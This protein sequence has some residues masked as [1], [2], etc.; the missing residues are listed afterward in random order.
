MKPPLPPPV[1]RMARAVDKAANKQ[2]RAAG[3][4]GEAPASP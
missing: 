2:Q 4:H 3:T 1:L